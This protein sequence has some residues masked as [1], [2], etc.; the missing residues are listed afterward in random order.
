MLYCGYVDPV[1]IRKWKNF[2]YPFSHKH[3]LV[4]SC[5]FPMGVPGA[6]L[7]CTIPS[8]V[9]WLCWLLASS[10]SSLI[11]VWRQKFF[12]TVQFQ[13]YRDYINSE[14]NLNSKFNVQQLQSWRKF[15]HKLQ[16]IQCIFGDQRTR[17]LLCI[18]KCV[19][20]LD[21]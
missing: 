6:I 2:L 10:F 21:L 9:E 16:H 12:Y 4:S 18:L 8:S 7:E 1:Y 3:F 17:N 20:N 11:K 14:D 5:H 15:P 13:F 19:Y